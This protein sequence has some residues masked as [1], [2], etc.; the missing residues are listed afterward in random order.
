M[1]VFSI[2]TLDNIFQNIGTKYNI[3]FAPILSV[4]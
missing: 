2:I 3:S 1:A 4:I